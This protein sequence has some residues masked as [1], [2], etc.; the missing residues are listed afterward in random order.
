MRFLSILFWLVV[1]V[2]VTL[3][4]A[5]NWRDVT[6]ALWGNL[7][8]EVKIPILVA[9]VFLIGFL[10]TWFIYRTRLWRSENRVKIARHGH[11]EEIRHEPEADE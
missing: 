8:A 7:E 2:L 4:A 6:I 1:L 5:E 11:L 10:P 9:I 3:F